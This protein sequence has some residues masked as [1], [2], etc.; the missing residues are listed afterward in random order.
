MTTCLFSVKASL[1]TCLSGLN[2]LQRLQY[3]LLLQQ[4]WQ[5]WRWFPYRIS[6]IMA[7]LAE[8]TQQYELLL[9]LNN[10]HRDVR[11]KLR[12][13]PDR[14]ATIRAYLINPATSNVDVLPRDWHRKKESLDW[15]MINNKL[16]KKVRQICGC[17]NPWYCLPRQIELRGVFF[18]HRGVLR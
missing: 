18:Y 1:T 16:W 2:P 11:R 15:Q 6:L 3:G 17:V 8:R 12:L 10:E 4:L 14:E 13:A 5:I 7:S 9:L